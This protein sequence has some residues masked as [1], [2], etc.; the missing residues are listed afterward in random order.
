MQCRVKREHESKQEQS[1]LELRGVSEKRTGLYLMGSPP[2]RYNGAGLLTVRRQLGCEAT[3]EL[4]AWGRPWDLICQRQQV[5]QLWH[6][7]GQIRQMIR[8]RKMGASSRHAPSGSMRTCCVG[9]LTIKL[10]PGLLSA[11]RVPSCG[12]DKSVD[13]T[14]S[15]AAEW[16]F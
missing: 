9:R 3:R 6:G 10:L 4:G 13:V 7:R 8:G 11:H 12:R 5:A 15:S 14:D 16:R 1:S 2:I